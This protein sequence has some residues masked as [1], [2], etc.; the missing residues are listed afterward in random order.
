MGKEGF[1][2]AEWARPECL[3]SLLERSSDWPKSM[4]AARCGVAETV[5]E[6]ELQVQ[7]L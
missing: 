7:D 3:A 4:E 5:T 6:T 2:F 1:P